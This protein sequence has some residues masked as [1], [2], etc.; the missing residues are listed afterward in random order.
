MVPLLSLVTVLRR[1][2]AR[3]DAEFFTYSML[4]VVGPGGGGYH[5]ILGTLIITA[6]TSVI[7]VPIGLMTA[8][9]LVEYGRGPSGARSRSW[10]TS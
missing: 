10:S 5:A 6:I 3:F 8:I 9:Y 1:G 2:L 7:S 4:G